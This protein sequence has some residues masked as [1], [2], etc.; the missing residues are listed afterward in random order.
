M[1]SSS[2]GV[3]KSA[4]VSVACVLARIDVLL[5]AVTF[6]VETFWWGRQRFLAH[7]L[8]L[9][10]ALTNH[11]V[12]KA[13]SGRK[14]VPCALASLLRCQIGSHF[15][16]PLPAAPVAP[17][18]GGAPPSNPCNS[19]S[20][21]RHL[22]GAVP[23]FALIPQPSGFLQ[24]LFSGRKHVPRHLWGTSGCLGSFQ[25]KADPRKQTAL[26]STG[27]SPSKKNKQGTKKRHQNDAKKGAGL[28]A[29]AN[30]VCACGSN[31]LKRVQSGT[32][33]WVSSGCRWPFCSERPWPVWEGSQWIP[34]LGVL[35]HL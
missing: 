16:R 8:S 34:V 31:G 6:V 2:S 17:P 25:S 7:L 27:I 23:S 24:G 13:L 26:M 1:F 15:P 30:Y 9:S 20:L 14:Q 19:A 32:A 22:A 4:S 11:S 3:R 29:G 12:P 28:A 18:C 21:Y 35:L 33:K 10:A 5:F